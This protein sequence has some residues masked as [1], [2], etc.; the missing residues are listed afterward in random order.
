[1]MEQQDPD[2]VSWTERI[3]VWWWGLGIVIFLV[4]L[5][6]FSGMVFSWGTIF[7]HER[8]GFR[9][10]PAVG[11]VGA[12]ALFLLVGN[13]GLFNLPFNLPRTAEDF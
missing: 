5:D 11:T 12:M 6:P 3:A 13:D 1:M 10:F 8:P 9:W 7:A 4:A 2:A